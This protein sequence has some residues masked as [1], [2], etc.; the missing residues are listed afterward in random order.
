MHRLHSKVLAL[1]AKQRRL[2]AELL[3]LLP[4][5]NRGDKAAAK[6]ADRIKADIFKISKKILRTNNAITRAQAAAKRREE[7]N[8]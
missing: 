3:E 5:A 4:Q 2:S 8:R 6:K 7:K 1:H